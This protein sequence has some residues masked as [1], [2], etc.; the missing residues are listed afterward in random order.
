[1]HKHESILSQPKTG[2]EPLVYNITAAVIS[3]V[4]DCWSTSAEQECH[5]PRE[6]KR[7]TEI[8]RANV[9]ENVEQM[10]HIVSHVFLADAAAKGSLRMKDALTDALLIACSVN[11]RRALSHPLPGSSMRL[12]LRR[13]E[14]GATAAEARLAGLVA[15][16]REQAGALA[17][18]VASAIATLAI[19]AALGAVGQRSRR[20]ACALGAVRRL[21]HTVVTKAT[22][23]Q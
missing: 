22:H 16:A 7:L 13:V 10:R 5:T 8:A 11:A 12:A 3:Q 20:R 1:M 4:C 23:S 21:S 17:I 15:H 9:V 18:C 6:A 19:V 14:I 2:Q